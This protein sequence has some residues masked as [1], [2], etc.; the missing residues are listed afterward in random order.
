MPSNRIAILEGYTQGESMSGF[1][2]PPRRKKRALKSSRRAKRSSSKT[3]L[4]RGQV[5]SAF[6]TAAVKCRVEAP[7]KGKYGSCMKREMRSLLGK[8]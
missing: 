4:T 7:Q 1:G 8:K 5:R 3:G 2:A 6:R